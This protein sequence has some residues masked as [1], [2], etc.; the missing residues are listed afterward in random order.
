MCLSPTYITMK[1]NHLKKRLER[2]AERSD[3]LEGGGRFHFSR[4]IFLRVLF[5]VSLFLFLGGLLYSLFWAPFL[6]VDTFEI[7]GANRVSAERIESIA[8]SVLDG[9]NRFQ[10]SH[11]NLI[12]VSSDGLAQQITSQITEI[13]EVEIAKVFPST[14]RITVQEYDT[15]MM[16]CGRVMVQ[17]DESLPEESQGKTQEECMSVDE[18]GLRGEAEDLSLE[19]FQSNPTLVIRVDDLLPSQVGDTIFSPEIRNRLFY[20]I[21]EL[22]YR[23]SLRAIGEPRLASLGSTHVEVLTD[24]GW[25]LLFDVVQEPRVSLRVLEAFFEQTRETDIRKTV[26][27]IDIRLLD[28]IFYQKKDEFLPQEVLTD[29]DGQDD[30]QVEDEVGQVVETIVVG[31]E[32]EEEEEEV[33]EQEENEEDVDLEIDQNDEQE[34]E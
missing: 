25:T 31:Q 33:N 13:E 17:A 4:Q 3:S 29:L 23:L 7:E 22:P 12:I 24:E 10:V 27:E 26:D 14:L 30:V 2:N 8:Y 5:Y 15:I 20:F 6:R 21:E 32:L 9:T 19:K 16:V 28:K 11:S 18:N 1:K 34:E